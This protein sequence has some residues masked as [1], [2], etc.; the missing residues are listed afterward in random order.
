M[1]RVAAALGFWQ[2]QREKGA[3]RMRI[4][5]TTPRTNQ[6]YRGPLF[7]QQPAI[8]VDANGEILIDCGVERWNNR[9]LLILNDAMARWLPSVFHEDG[10]GPRPAAAAMT[11]IWKSRGGRVERPP[12]P[13]PGVHVTKE[14][15]E[16]HCFLGNDNNGYGYH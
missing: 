16:V 13:R 4:T 7:L 2:Q 15:E 10:P 6:F 12:I 8:T 14:G 11:L 3:T 9:W 1:E 5:F